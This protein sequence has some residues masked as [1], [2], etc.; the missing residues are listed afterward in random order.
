MV[1]VRLT[2]RELAVVPGTTKTTADSNRLT[3]MARRFETIEGIPGQLR[4]VLEIL[5]PTPPASK[6]AELIPVIPD[7]R[8]DADELVT[9]HVSSIANP[10]TRLVADGQTLRLTFNTYTTQKLV[11]PCPCS[12][13]NPTAFRSSKLLQNAIGQLFVGYTGQISH[14]GECKECPCIKVNDARVNF[15]YYFPFWFLSRALE[16]VFRNSELAGPSLSLRTYR[17][18]ADESLLFHFAKLGMIPGIQLLFKDKLASPF[19]ISSK[20]G[21][22][23][24]HVSLSAERNV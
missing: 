18:V 23:A 13:H 19:D 7:N 5:K 11:R 20:T 17:V 10:G 2:L 16:V 6:P 15:T 8:S 4:E 21:R 24:L 1:H 22:S 12:C 9:R 14:L 3:E